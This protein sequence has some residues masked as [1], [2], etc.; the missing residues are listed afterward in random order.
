MKKLLDIKSYKYNIQSITQVSKDRRIGKSA[1]FINI[2][3][4]RAID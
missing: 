1:D 2:R 4:G 3:R